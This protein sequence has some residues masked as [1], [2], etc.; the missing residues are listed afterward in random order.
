MNP[1][2]YNPEQGFATAMEAQYPNGMCEQLVRVFDEICLEKGVRVQPA[3]YK[4]PRVDKQPRGRATPQL[5]P[6]YEK[7][8]Q[9]FVRCIAIDR[10]KALFVRALQACS[11]R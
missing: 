3:D 5:I 1:W 7:V 9:C 6:E 4:P 10:C 2:G 11:S 8:L